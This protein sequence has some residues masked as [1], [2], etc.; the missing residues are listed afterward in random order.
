M[1]KGIE[2]AR[3]DLNKLP[4][5]G[6]RDQAFRLL[7][8]IESLEAESRK[9][10]DDLEARLATPAPAASELMLWRWLPWVTAALA[11]YAAYTGISAILEGEFCTYGRGGS[12]NCSHGRLAQFQ[13][14]TIMII[15]A[16]IFLLPLP[17]SRWRTVALWILGL[18]VLPSLFLGLL[19]RYLFV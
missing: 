12:V 16:I 18:S 1:D 10:L 6:Q 15:A 5:S 7:D 13:G 8:E 19:E 14:V 3:Q 2:D 17:T 9:T 4:P 11:C